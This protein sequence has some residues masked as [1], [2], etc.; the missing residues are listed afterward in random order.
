ML[1]QKGRRPGLSA[2]RFASDPAV[3]A[4]IG[5]RGARAGLVIP[6]HVREKLPVLAHPGTNSRLASQNLVRDLPVSGEV[7]L[8]VQE[9]VVGPGRMRP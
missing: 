7:V 6:H 5:R 8:T 4:D 3:G 2:S 1:Y 9:I